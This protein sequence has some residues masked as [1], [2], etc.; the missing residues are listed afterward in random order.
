MMVSTTF[1][2][3]S[4]TSGSRIFLSITCKYMTIGGPIMKLISA[5]DRR[6]VRPGLLINIWKQEGQVM[7]IYK[8]MTAGRSGHVYL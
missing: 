8:D 7:S 6:Q 5:Y 1:G 2:F 4:W 3:L